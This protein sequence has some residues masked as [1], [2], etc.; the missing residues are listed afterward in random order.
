MMHPI[1]DPVTLWF[2]REAIVGSVPFG[3]PGERRS[4]DHR[5]PRIADSTRSSWSRFNP[6]E[7]MLTT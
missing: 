5:F 7:A 3:W 4:G 6:E 2:R 1:A